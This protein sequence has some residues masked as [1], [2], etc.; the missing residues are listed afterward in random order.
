MSL[1]NSTLAKEFILW[2]FPDVPIVQEFLFVLLLFTYML[3]LFTNTLVIIVTLTERHLQTPMYFFLRNFSLLEI[4]YVSVTVPKILATISSQGR[5]ISVSSCITQLFFFFFLSSTECFLLGVMAFDR[6]LAVCHPL[7]YSALMNHTTC[8]KITI[9]SWF[10]GFIT[11]FPPV[12][13]ISQLQFCRTN[14]INHFFC[15]AP[16]LL[17][18]SCRDASFNEFLDFICAGLVIMTS[19]TVTLMSYIYIIITVLKIPTKIGRRK[20]FSTCGSHLT[21][22]LVYYGTVTFIY[23]RP[24][25]G[26]T[27]SLNRSVAVFYTVLI[28]ILNPIIYCLRN[29]EV[30]LAIKKLVSLQSI[31]Q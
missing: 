13:L 2:G 24:K 5:V 14:T 9:C 31:R 15:D 7:R 26:F 20:V 27:L 17:Q 6:Y 10:G 25:G 30:K 4:C 18:T 11:T 28:P 19:F 12:F 8:Q 22:V 29:K 3:T 1:G 16:P 21:V 23:V